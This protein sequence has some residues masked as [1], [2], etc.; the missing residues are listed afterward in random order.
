MKAADHIEV[1]FRPLVFCE[2]L[3]YVLH[4]LRLL[5][6][7]SLLTVPAVAG[8]VQPTTYDSARATMSSNDDG[9]EF[10]QPLEIASE[11]DDEHGPMSC[12]MPDCCS[13]S[14]CA[15]TAATFSP[16][17]NV[18]TVHLTYSEAVTL[19][20]QRIP[21]ASLPPPPRA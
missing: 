15:C 4:M 7:L 16:K 10:Q 18:G 9:G 12:G 17:L 3:E 6:V 21:R 8:A 19:R 13:M 2:S 5:I 1:D 20:L 11:D 14:G